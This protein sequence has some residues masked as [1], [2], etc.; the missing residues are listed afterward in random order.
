[1]LV[2]FAAVPSGVEGTP[3]EKETIDEEIAKT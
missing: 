2:E 3:I 1:L